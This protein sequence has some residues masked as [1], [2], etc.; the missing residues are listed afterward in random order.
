ME[1]GGRGR[2]YHNNRPYIVNNIFL[3]FLLI[4]RSKNFT[5]GG[6]GI[7]A[8]LVLSNFLAHFTSR[9]NSSFYQNVVLEILYK[10]V[11]SRVQKLFQVCLKKDE[12]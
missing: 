6:P 12:K 9:R 10:M 7:I 1:I 11:Y 2:V 4:E 3:Y 5:N 8:L